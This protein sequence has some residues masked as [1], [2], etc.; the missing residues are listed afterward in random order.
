MI[1]EWQRLV[2]KSVNEAKGALVTA[3]LV[4]IAHAEGELNVR[5]ADFR[6]N[7]VT[8]MFDRKSNRVTRIIG[9]G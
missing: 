9:R 2:G 3:G 8:F 4:P 1:D 5:T 6:P 7:R